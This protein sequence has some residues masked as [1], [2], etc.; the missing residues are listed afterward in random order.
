[1]ATDEKISQLTSGNPALSGDL[2]PIDRSGSNFAV[3]AASIAS[4]SGLGIAVVNVSA[5]QMHSAHSVPI[6]LLAAPGANNMISV[7][8]ITTQYIPLTTGFGGVG[9]WQYYM[10]SDIAANGWVVF[11]VLSGGNTQGTDP[12]IYSSGPYNTG[13]QAIVPSANWINQ[14]LMFDN[15]A[16]QSSGGD[17]SLQITVVYTIQSVV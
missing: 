6:Q 13:S 17:G 2:I 1:M 3:T 16:D 7:L 10:G 5:A 15:S 14:P 9:A 4:L 8:K 12:Q 11:P